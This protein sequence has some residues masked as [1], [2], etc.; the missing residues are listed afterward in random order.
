MRQ[1]CCVDCGWRG[2]LEDMDV[3][4]SQSSHRGI[5]LYHY[6]CPG[7][8]AALDRVPP[9]DDTWWDQRER[10]LAEKDGIR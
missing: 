5:T 6:I 9:M 8:G 7:C 2:L 3:R 4:T 10:F 1:R